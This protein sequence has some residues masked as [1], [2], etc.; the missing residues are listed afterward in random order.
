MLTGC[1]GG[2]S[3][4]TPPVAAYALTVDSTNPASGVAISVSPA[5]NKNTA[6]G[7]SSL[8]LTYNAGTSV[9]LTAPTASGSNAFSSWSGC[10]TASKVT[11]T[12]NLN[13]NTTVTANYAVTTIAVMPNPT[14]ATIG[15]TVQFAAAINGTASSAVTW[16]VSAPQGSLSPGTISAIG[17]NVTPYP[18][19][20]TVT[21]T[22]TSTQ[23][24]NQSASVPLTHAAP[25][26]TAGPALSVDAGNQTHAISPFIYGM[27][28]D[29]RGRQPT[30]AAHKL[31]PVMALLQ[32][33]FGRVAGSLGFV[34]P[35]K[36]AA[37]PMHFHAH[38]GIPG[39]IKIR[40]TT[41]CLDA[42]SVLVEAVPI[43]VEMIGA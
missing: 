7:S 41:Q 23:D 31:E 33:D 28:F 26:A 30:A 9:T 38:A 22:A 43:L 6:S 20:A 24:T 32:H 36:L 10:T 34:V 12:V 29:G 3:T 8:T 27:R 1:G 21:V 2:G 42:D 15:G 13:A 5:D 39:G 11:C 18:A 37:K 16:S 35:P 17:R 19:P 25:A 14:T 4:T 40:G